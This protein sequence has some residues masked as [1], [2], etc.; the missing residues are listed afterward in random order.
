MAVF[1]EF[2]D[3]LNIDQLYIS[4][5]KTL[6]LF[7]T[8]SAK[9]IGDGE[10]FLCY[11]PDYFGFNF[12]ISLDKKLSSSPHRNTDFKSLS[13]LGFPRTIDQPVLNIFVIHKANGTQLTINLSHGVAD[14]TS[15]KLFTFQLFSFLKNKGIQITPLPQKKIYLEKSDK[16][17]NTQ[18]NYKNHLVNLE[19]FSF[20][21]GYFNEFIIPFDRIKS[22]YK[23]M[24]LSKDAEDLKLHD[25]ISSL[26]LKCLATHLSYNNKEINLI[27]PVDVRNLYGSL[28]SYYVG[29]GFAEAFC[30]WKIQEFLSI[31]SVDLA[32]QIRQVINKFSDVNFL[33]SKLEMKQNGLSFEK[34]NK[35]E[36]HDFAYDEFIALTSL[37]RSNS[38][39]SISDSTRIGVIA[40][41]SYNIAVFRINCD[42]VINITSPQQLPNLALLY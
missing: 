1:F 21:S 8:F 31:D 38:L 13:V 24:Y 17:L 37:G 27:I 4:I 23:E 35:G 3:Q 2:R 22:L 39:L 42:Y 29:N 9:F 18:V 6:K 10:Y 25:V 36:I 40:D 12:S 34:F 19:N 33:K 30:S 5:L 41:N 32:L 15:L 14:G 16:Q 28:N 7:P 26:L 11:I 20:R